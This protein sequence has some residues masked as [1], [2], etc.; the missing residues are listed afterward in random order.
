MDF[1]DFRK[2]FIEEVKAESATSGIGSSAA[3][4]QTASA[5]MLNADIL[6]DAIMP[7]YCPSI[8]R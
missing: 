8:P 4:L 7:A 3:F 5:Y 2:D 6:P 1:E